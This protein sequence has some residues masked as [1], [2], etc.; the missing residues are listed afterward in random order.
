MPTSTTRLNFPAYQQANHYALASAHTTGTSRDN[1]AL[2]AL[3]PVGAEGATE[4]ANPCPQV[5]QQNAPPLPMLQ[6][7]WALTIAQLEALPPET[8]FKNAF[9]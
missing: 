6:S 4:F 9:V 2:L 5:V 7:P 3:D 1:P 8:I